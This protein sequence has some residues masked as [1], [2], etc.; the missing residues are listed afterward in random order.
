VG[1]DDAVVEDVGDV[2]LGCKMAEDGRVIFVREG[3]DGGD[4]EVLVALGEM[5]SGR[6]DVGFGVA[7]DSAVAI[8]DEEAMRCEAS[9]VDLCGGSRNCTESEEQR[10]AESGDTTR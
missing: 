2:G 3:T 6:G 9:G 5:A 4:P 1:G 7:G 10:D 8:E